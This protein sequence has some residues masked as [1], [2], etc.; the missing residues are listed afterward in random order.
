[1]VLT[2]TL[3]DMTLIPVVVRMTFSEQAIKGVKYIYQDFDALTDKKDY[4]LLL[5]ERNINTMNKIEVTSS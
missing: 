3:Y 5:G 2:A 4:F 1:M